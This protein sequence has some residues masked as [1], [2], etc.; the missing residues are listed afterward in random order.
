MKTST[1]VSAGNTILLAAL[2]A[3]APV[4]K[5]QHDWQGAL[6]HKGGTLRDSIVGR[7]SGPEGRGFYGVYYGP[8]V[9]HGTRPH[10]ILPRVKKALWWE[11]ADHPV[12]KVNHPGTKPNDFVRRAVTQA[13]PALRVLMLENG[14]QII[15]LIAERTGA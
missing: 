11:G 9:V 13:E 7:A 14:R 15:R 10:L 8:Y 12:G 4:G 1:L 5:D 3:A 2:K 6:T